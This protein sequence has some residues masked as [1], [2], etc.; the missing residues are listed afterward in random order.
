MPSDCAAA[1]VCSTVAAI[2]GFYRI[3]QNRHPCKSG[4]NL[5]QKLEPLASQFRRLEARAGYV[6]SWP[7]EARDQ[8]VSDRVGARRH[9]HWDGLGKRL[10]GAGCRR[11]FGHD[12]IQM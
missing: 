2:L 7:M 3:R 4:N 6:A 1:F 10:H 8:A 11:A 9:D 12:D 5:G